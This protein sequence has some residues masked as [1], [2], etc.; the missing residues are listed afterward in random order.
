MS[1]LM[2][3]DNDPGRP[4][5]R[6]YD[7]FTTETTVVIIIADDNGEVTGVGA[8]GATGLA[9]IRFFRGVYPA[10]FSSIPIEAE[11]G[12]FWFAVDADAGFRGGSKDCPDVKNLS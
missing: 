11:G 1:Q 9:R 6:A 3:N 2:T 8:S 10:K 12:I 5:R 4:T 7:E